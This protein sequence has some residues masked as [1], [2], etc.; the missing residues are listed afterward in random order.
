MAAT[1]KKTKE[2]EKPFQCEFCSRGFVRE[3]SLINH[4]CEQK[5]RW[6]NK[7]EKHVR[8][9]FQAW[10]RWYELC[11]TSAKPKNKTYQEFMKSRYYSAFVKFGRHIVDTNLVNPKE[12]IDFVIKN[13]IKLDDWCKNS[14]YEYYIRQLSR[15][16][17]VTE[18]MERQL[19][20]MEQWAKETGENWYDFF[21]KIEPSL[22]LKWIRTGR[23]SPWTLLN[24]ESANELF[25]RMT[26]EQ[27][28]LIDKYIETA[29]WKKNFARRK[30]DA[31]FVKNT[32]KEYGI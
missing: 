5:R 6:F 32:L 11:G 24:A 19:L 13:S 10:L 2:K 3:K 12:F 22:A 29:W 16:E 9:G 8:L 18:A 7:D 28:M 25:D 15:K 31:K 17:D 20:L 4:F 21:R 27:I 30:S 26:D 1:K 14:V 23:I